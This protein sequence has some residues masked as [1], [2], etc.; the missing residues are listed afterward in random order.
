[1]V[2]NLSVTYI[3]LESLKNHH[4][5]KWWLLLDD[6]KPLHEKNGRSETTLNKMVVGLPGWKVLVAQSI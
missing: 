2:V 1:M 6:D 5:S 3:S 4:C